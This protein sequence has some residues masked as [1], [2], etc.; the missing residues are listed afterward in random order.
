MRRD[1][2]LWEAAGFLGMS[3]EALQ[4]NY[5]HHPRLYAWRGQCH[6]IQVTAGFDG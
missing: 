5:R 2:P 4:G 1:T 3:V 6:Y